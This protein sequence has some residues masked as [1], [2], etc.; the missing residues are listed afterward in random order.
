MGAT[1]G[2][3]V[4]P[5]VGATVGPAVGAA[6]GAAVGDV[7]L[8]AALQAGVSGAFQPAAAAT[9]GSGRRRQSRQC[10]ESVGSLQ[11]ALGSRAARAH[12]PS[13][14]QQLAVALLGQAP[15]T[16]AQLS[17]SHSCCTAGLV[18]PSR[19]VLPTRTARPWGT[20]HPQNIFPKHRAPHPP[21]RR[22]RAPGKAQR[23]AWHRA[24]R[25]AAPTPAAQCGC[26]FK[27]AS[28]A[29]KG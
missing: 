2:A 24:Q 9:A 16:L 26:T 25:F 20:A 28:A 3:A 29:F 23:Q 19:P 8:E 5:V 7:E 13:Q 4:G 14:L 6:V 10:I 11:H 18:S 15:G 21:S 1:V 22:S 12:R 27:R 17:H